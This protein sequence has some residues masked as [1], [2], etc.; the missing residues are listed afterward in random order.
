MLDIMLFRENPEQIKES[1]RKRGKP[2]NLVDEVIS[3]DKQWRTLLRKVEA[4]KFE[5]NEISEKINRLKKE[6]K[7]AASEIKAT[8]NVVD[9]ITKLDIDI[10]KIEKKRD[11]LRYKIGNILHKTVPTGTEAKVV[12]TW[13]Q[14]PKFDFKPKSHVDLLADLDVA[15]VERA[16]KVAGARFYY[17]K[18]EL[19]ILNIALQLFAMK[20]LYKK[21]YTPML[22]PFAMN[23]KAIAGAAELSDFENTLYKLEGEDLFLIA[24]AEQTLAGYHMDEIIDEKELPIKFVGF[25]T[26]FRREAGSHGKDTK[27]I[28]RVHQFD[29]VEQYVLCKPE[30]SWKMHEEMIKNAEEILKVLGIPHRVVNIAARDM[31][32]NAA[33]KY[34]TEAWMPAQKE[35]REVGSCSNCTDYQSRKLNIRFQRRDGKREIPHVLNATL[36]ATERTIVAVIENFQ[37]PNGAVKIPKVLWPYTGFREIRPG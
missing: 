37:Q 19:A 18:K 3:Y 30:D 16:A 11:E 13:G 36:C 24:T 9:Q 35:Y 32:D 2:A 26:N 8:Q 29:K 20:Y 33:K 10:K 34:D 22:T 15:D 28:F 1:Q 5:R 25:S 23:R 31:N 27:G 17:L 14:K 7:S 12:R 6:G 4:L 21:G